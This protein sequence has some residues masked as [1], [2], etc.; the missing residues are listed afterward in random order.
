MNP[1]AWPFGLFLPW[2]QHYSTGTALIFPLSCLVCVAQKHC[3]TS[4]VKGPSF[5]AAPASVSDAA[6]LVLEV[7]RRF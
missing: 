4:F 7:L 6:F 2:K 3:C 1:E 5:R